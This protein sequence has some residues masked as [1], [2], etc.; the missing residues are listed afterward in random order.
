[1]IRFSKE[2]QEEATFL[3]EQPVGGCLLVQNKKKKTHSA[4]DGKTFCNVSGWSQVVLKWQGG[5]VVHQRECRD[6]KVTA[7]RSSVLFNSRYVDAPPVPPQERHLTPSGG[8]VYWVFNENAPDEYKIAR[9]LQNDISKIFH[10][11]A[12]KPLHRLV[13]LTCFDVFHL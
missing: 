5:R 3:T 8:C 9:A 12:I 2:L 1:M 7:S 10:L 6:S 4:V 11:S 13:W